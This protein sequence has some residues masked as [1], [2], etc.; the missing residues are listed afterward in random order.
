MAALTHGRIDFFVFNESATTLA[1][2]IT[3]LVTFR[4][5]RKFVPVSI[6]DEIS[7]IPEPRYCFLKIASRNA[8]N[9]YGSTSVGSSLRA[10]Q[11]RG[12]GA[13]SKGK[14]ISRERK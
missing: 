3:V 1:L 4:M 6:R 13:S 10:R 12:N 11:E 2:E 7:S 8:R 14:V 5:I 9:R